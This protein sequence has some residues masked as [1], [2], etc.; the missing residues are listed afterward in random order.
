MVPVAIATVAC[1]VEIDFHLEKWVGISK[2]RNLSTDL[3][4]F[5][6]IGVVKA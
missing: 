3:K 4:G 1:E 2:K 6:V 5:N